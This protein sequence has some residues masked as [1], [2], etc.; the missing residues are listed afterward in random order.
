ITIPPTIIDVLDRAHLAHVSTPL[1]G[2]GTNAD[3]Q[4]PR[5]SNDGQ[6]VAFLSDASNLGIGDSGVHRDLYRR[7]MQAGTVERL[8]VGV[9]GEPNAPTEALDM[10]A[11][12]SAIVMSSLA[13][14]LVTEP[15]V[16][17]EIYLWTPDG[18]LVS[19]SAACP[20]CNNEVQNLASISS[21]GEH[22]A[23]AT[24]RQMM[25]SD[26]EPHFDVF[27]VHL[28]TG[29]TTHDSLNGDGQNGAQFWGS[30][31]FDPHLSSDGAVVT[32]ASA[33]H[34]LDF[35][36]I[37]VQNFHAYVKDRVGAR[38]TRT[39]RHDGD[40]LNCDG[41]HRATGSSSPFASTDGNIAVFTSR[42]TIGVT[43][44]QP[45]DQAGFGDV[46]VRD[47]GA[48]TTTRVSVG[49]DGTEAD[50]DSFVVDISDDARYVL[51]RSD[52]T[53]L[54]PDDTN[55]ATDLFVHDR[56]DGTTTRVS[57]GHEYGELVSGVDSGAGL[58]PNGRWVVFATRDPL[59]PSDGNDDVLDVYRVQLH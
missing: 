13:T 30:N 20:G 4:A 8:T 50:G 38:L 28:A 44:N 24:R 32:F 29:A 34:N 31:A 48:L 58:S 45:A 52:A 23:Y 22:A 3:S 12:G 1:V 10:S 27:T 57:Y 53:N 51:M 18:G 16:S 6:W 33:A 54:V 39:S 15:V 35:P 37:V 40:I 11:D 14:N 59:S 49:H 7:D 2:N 36:D 41:I 47:I 55:G 42:C 25:P 21:D 9:D 19:I 43:A 17:R 46:F 26:T 56:D 5:V